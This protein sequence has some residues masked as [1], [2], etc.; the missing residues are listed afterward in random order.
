VNFRAS[1]F[2]ISGIRGGTQI[3][4]SAEYDL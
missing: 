2:R 4:K 1:D 3:A